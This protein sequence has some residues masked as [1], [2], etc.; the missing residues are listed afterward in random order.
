MAGYFYKGRH[1][2]PTHKARNIATVTATTAI[3][4][5]GSSLLNT[6]AY[7]GPPGGWGPIIQCESGNR[8]IPNSSG[9]STA[10]GFFQFIDGTWRGLGG[11]QYASRAI[12][13]SFAE[14]L[15]I[16]EKAYAQSGTTP[17]NASKSCWAGKVGATPKPPTNSANA[18]KRTAKKLSGATK[19]ATCTRALLYYDACDPADLGDKVQLPI[20]AKDGTPARVVTVAGKTHIVK[21]GE[22]LSGIAG[23]SWKRVYEANKGLIGSNPNLI[24]PGQKLIV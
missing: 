3:A 14:Q 2:V 1:R 19:T 9:A 20:R 13:A 11:T 5:G 23:P 17:W 21:R 15:A 6:A 10:S 24:Q 12:G 18:A 4:F 22:S 8:N 16:A 7:A